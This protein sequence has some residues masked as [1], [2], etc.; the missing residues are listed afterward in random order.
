MLNDL[1][2]FTET[3]RKKRPFGFVG[4]PQRPADPDAFFLYF[5]DDG[6]FGKEE[7]AGRAGFWLRGGALGRGRAARLR[8][9]AGRSRRP[10]RGRRAARRHGDGAPRLAIAAGERGPGTGGA[11][12]SSRPGAGSATTTPTSTSCGSRSRRGAPLAGRPRGRRVRGRAA[13]HGPA[14]RGAPMSERLAPASPSASCRGLVL[15]AAVAIDL[16]PRVRR[17]L[18]ER[19]RDLPRDGGQPRL[20]RGPR[21]HRPRDLARVRA[22]YPGRPAGRLPE[23]GRRRLRDAARSSTRRPLALPG[24]RGARSRGCSAS[25]AACCVLNALVFVGRSVA[26]LRGAAPR[27]GAAA[28]RRAGALAVLAGGVV[29]VYL[30]WQTPEIFNLGLV[31]LR[32]RGLAT[33]AMGPRPPCSSAL[34]AYSKPTNLALALPLLLE[35][36]LAAARPGRA[37]ERVVESARRG[38]VVAAVVAA[39][40]GLTGSRPARSTTRAASARPSTTATPSTPGVTFDSAGVWMT[41]DHLGPARRRPRRGRAR[42]RASRRRARPRSCGG[43]SCLNL[44]YFW[45]GRFGGALPY[46]PG[47]AAAVAPVPARR[48]RASGTA[49]W[50][51]VAL[52]VSWLGYILAHP[53][54]LVRGRRRDRQPL[55]PEPRAARAAAAAARARA[56]G[57]RPRCR[58]PAACSLAPIA[59]LARPPLAAAGRARDAGRLP[60]CCRPSSRCS[61][62][63]R[64]SPTSGAS[65]GRTTRPAATPPGG[66]PGDPPPYYLWFLDDGTFGQEESF[67]EEGFWLRGGESAEV[68]L[69][70][71]APASRVRLV[72]TAGPAGDIVTARLGSRAPAG[73]PAAAQDAG[74][75]LRRAAAAL[76]ATTGRSLYPLRLGSRYGGGAGPGPEDA[77]VV[78][79]GRARRIE[80]RAAVRASPAAPSA[81]ARRGP[82]LIRRQRS[83]A[84]ASSSFCRAEPV[85][86]RCW[87]A[88]FTQDIAS[89]ERR[90]CSRNARRSAW[91]WR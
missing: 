54:Q 58:W 23:A 15:L 40:F 11:R 59:R 26:R 29:P 41:T 60:R 17:A 14:V 31:D 24:R 45:V 86:G 88:R 87:Q 82:R 16:P 5:L 68:V 9:R 62:T 39:G 84:F 90:C 4:N 43:P 33:R 53:R 72:V 19:R 42:A 89:V 51:L 35:P 77:R 8:P 74:D 7:W 18:L 71:L 13:R 65:G 22:S 57:P 46:F 3:W 81:A 6:T 27:V 21:V 70:A 63:C 28:R 80:R 50:P 66:A 91:A 44:G 75:R 52:V 38:A 48:A 78:R 32:P 25:T 10:A 85:I 12:S 79:A 47:F 83:G 67:G 64:S 49:G 20:R 30:L 61:A 34:A 76:S 36:L 55:L 56:P 73:R 37:A 1:S 2:V 69:Q